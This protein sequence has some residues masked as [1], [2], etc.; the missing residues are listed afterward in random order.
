[1]LKFMRKY[2]TGYMVKAM[3]GLIIVVFVFWGVGSFREGDKTVA[4]VGPYKISFIEYQEE[5]N[6]LLNMYRMIYKDKLDENV[7]R[8]LKLKEMAMY[9]LVDRYILLIKANEIGISVSDKEFKEY[10]ENVEMFKRDGKFNEKVFKEILK[11]NGLDPKRFEQS[12]RNAILNTKMINLIKDTGALTGE[13]DFWN[14]YVKEK[15]KINLGYVEFDPSSFRSKINV[16]DQEVA[17]VYE[18]EKDTKS[19]ENVYRLKYLVI[20]EKTNIKDDAA[21]M[22]L[23]KAKDLEAYG[24]QKGLQVVDLGQMKEGDALK[25]LKNLKADEWL[26]ELK[27]GEISLP[28]RVDSKSYIVQVVDIEKGKP[29]DKV[30]VMKEIREHLINGKA[31][32]LA[33]NAAQESIDKKSFDSK[34]DTGLIPRT[35]QAIPKVGQIP[36]DDIGILLLSKE[37]PIYRKPLEIDGKYY[38]FYFKGEKL[39]GKDEWEKDKDSYKRYVLSKGKGDFLKSFIETL[40]KKEKAE[41]EWKDIG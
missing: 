3:F 36:R 29:L 17:S 14:S 4:V 11:R 18:K 9:E 27:K 19:G 39:P 8:E 10:L 7:L 35:A 2:A 15:G 21:Y 34:K 37:S 24:K 23:L 5:Y 16:D 1:M 41:I 26:K 31:K 6:R 30:V 20:D 40:R 12:E 28:V 13:S 38:V 25:K 32:T 22:E 33:K